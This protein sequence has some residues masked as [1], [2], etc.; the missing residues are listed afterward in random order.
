MDKQVTMHDLEMALRQLYGRTRGKG[1]GRLT[2]TDEN[3]VRAILIAQLGSVALPG[4]ELD[5]NLLLVKQVGALENDAEAALA[6]LLSDAI[7]N[8]HHVGGGAAARHGECGC[9]RIE[10]EE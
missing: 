9:V 10:E 1:E 4:L 3:L 6:D 5:G 2:A 7:V 8:A